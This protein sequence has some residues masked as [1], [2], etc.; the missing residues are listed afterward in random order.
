MISIKTFIQETPEH[1]SF[2]L[3]G[4]LKKTFDIWFV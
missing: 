4:E 1:C 2:T 3:Q